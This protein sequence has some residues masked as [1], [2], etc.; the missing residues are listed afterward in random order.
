MPFLRSHNDALEQIE[1]ALNGVLEALEQAGIAVD[2]A[3]AAAAAADAAQGTAEASA[4]ELARINSYTTPTSVLSASD[5]G[6]DA[7]ITVIGHTRVYPVQGSIDVP[8]VAIEGPVNLNGLA[9]STGYYVYYDDTTLS[10]T[11]PSYQTT[12]SAADAQVGKAAGRHF[13]GYVMTPADGGGSTGG[14]GGSPPGGGGGN[15]IP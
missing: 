13:V 9:F 7:R 6:S 1:G 3:N 12:T 10:D 2:L 15:P 4:R 14:T 11:T 5:N 8:D